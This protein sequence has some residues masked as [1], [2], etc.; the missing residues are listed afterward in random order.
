MNSLEK[1]INVKNQSDL[2]KR[3]QMYGAALSKQTEK[4]KN[5][6]KKGDKK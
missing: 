2:M 3:C 4:L 6:T 1:E 5:D